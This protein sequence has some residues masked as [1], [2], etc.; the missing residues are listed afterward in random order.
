MRNYAWSGFEMNYLK[1]NWKNIILVLLAGVAVETL[2]AIEKESEIWKKLMNG[3]DDIAD[4]AADGINNLV[5]NGKELMAKAQTKL[6][7]HQRIG[8][9]SMNDLV[10]FKPISAYSNMGINLN[11]FNLFLW[12]KF[13]YRLIKLNNMA[14]WQEH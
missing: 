8:H 1:E 4:N 7:L 13:F 6:K 2:L 9:W 12:H 3:L 11:N 10:I 5:G 14:N